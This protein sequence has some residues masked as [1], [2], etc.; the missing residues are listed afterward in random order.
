MPIRRRTDTALSLHSLHVHS[1]AIGEF[2]Q[3]NK[4]GHSVQEPIVLIVKN[5]NTF[6]MCLKKLERLDD[7][8]FDAD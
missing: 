4:L 8:I 3:C 5:Y 1:Y 6:N 2:I 7:E